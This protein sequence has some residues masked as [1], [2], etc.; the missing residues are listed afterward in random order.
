MSDAANTV[1]NSLSIAQE[2]NFTIY[3]FLVAFLVTIES[4]R[5]LCFL[6]LLLVRYDP[7]FIPLDALASDSIMPSRY[8]QTVKVCRAQKRSNRVL[9]MERQNLGKKKCPHLSFA[10][11]GTWLATPQ[12]EVDQPLG[13]EF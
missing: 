11:T 8:C 9:R 3:A 4:K 2:S 7:I 10:E 6:L 12:L 5:A 1:F 13:G